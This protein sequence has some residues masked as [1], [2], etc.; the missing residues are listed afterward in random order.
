MTSDTF[1]FVQKDLRQQSEAQEEK[2]V[3]TKTISVSYYVIILL[4]Y[5]IGSS[6]CSVVY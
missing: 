2:R 3:N 1:F 5:K 4:K 6:L